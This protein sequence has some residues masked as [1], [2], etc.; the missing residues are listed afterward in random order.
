MG[1]DIALFPELW[2]I[3]SHHF[4]DPSWG[5]EYERW[6]GKHLWGKAERLL[7]SGIL[8]AQKQQEL[9]DVAQALDPIRLVQQVEQTAG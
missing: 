8:S 1:A 6:R 4:V 5:H 3:G 9:I 7:L 2:Y